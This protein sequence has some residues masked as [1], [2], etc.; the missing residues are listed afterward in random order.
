MSAHGHTSDEEMEEDVQVHTA[1]DEGTAW[2]DDKIES[3]VEYDD[4]ESPPPELLFD[5]RL[6]EDIGGMHRVATSNVTNEMLRD[7]AKIG[8]D[9][10]TKQTLYEYLVERY[11]PRSPN[12]MLEDYPRLYNGGYGPT[13]HA[14]AAT[15][16]PTGAFLYF[17]QPTF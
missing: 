2:D 17:A 15:V 13:K 1:G 6:L 12:A 8:W 11:E 7:M 9:P 10:F 14:L 16:S 5:A 4:N 3:T